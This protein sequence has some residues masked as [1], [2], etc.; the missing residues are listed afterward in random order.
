MENRDGSGVAKPCSCDQLADHLYEGFYTVDVERRILSWNAGAEGITGFAAQEVKG[1]FCWND[2]LRHMDEE[3]TLLCRK[4]CPLSLTLKDGQVRTVRVYLF[5][6]LG[7]R[8]PVRI[9]VFPL[10]DANGNVV[11]AGEVFA[12]DTPLHRMEKRIRELEER[13][14]FD[15][16]TELP[17]RR[18]IKSFLRERMNLFLRYGM[19]FGVLFIDLDNFKKVNDQFGH[20]A[21]DL[22]LQAVSRTLQNNIRRSDMVGRWG[23][24]E[25]LAVLA[26]VNPKILEMTA[27]KLLRLIAATEIRHEGNAIAG[28]ISLGATLVK[29]GDALDGLVARA[30]KLMYL[31]KAKGR[32]RYSI[33][34][35]AGG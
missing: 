13:S 4:G 11:G 3:G 19:T 29:P 15:E 32:N 10:F 27:R 23:G 33:D 25:F 7:H 9:R 1:S 22:L 24:E 6:K 21:G 30:D 18:Y 26:G 16:L 14:L 31:S 20:K 12:E 28:T 34:S 5:H 35:A 2:I 17:N 8:V